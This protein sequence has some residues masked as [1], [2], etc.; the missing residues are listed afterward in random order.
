MSGSQGQQIDAGAIQSFQDQRKV[1]RTGGYDAVQHVYWQ[2]RTSQKRGPPTPGESSLATTPQDEPAAAASSQ[3]SQEP[4]L[5]QPLA[6]DDAT[7]VSLTASNVGVDI[8]KPGNVEQWLQTKV[9]TT[10]DVVRL[11]RGYHKGVIRP[12]L[13]NMALQLETAIKTIDD[14]VFQCKKELSWM[15]SENRAQQRHACGLQVILSGWPAGLKP[16][17]RLFQIGWMLMQVPEIKNFLSIRGHINDHTAREWGRYF[18]VLTADPVTIPQGQFWS[19]ITMIAFRSWSERQAF[20]SKFA[21]G[22]GTP[23]YTDENTPQHGKHVKVSPCSPQWQRKLESPLRV[24][25]ACINAHPDYNAPT[26]VILWK[27][28]TLMA[29][30]ESKE[31]QEDKI[32]WARLFYAVENDEFKGR[33]EIHPDLNRLLRSGPEDISSK[34]PS[35]WEE[36]WNRIQDGPQRELGR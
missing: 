17:M 27:T 32:A 20:M 2:H 16:E 19:T 15:A 6:F 26:L 30:S 25:L 3:Q 1:M 31:F 34:E 24:V 23:L 7:A 22:S 36:Q 13:F 35:L 10:Q 14:R 18:N 21:G 5:I 11:I 8:N 28:L 33:L 29:P 9:T 12:E 4:T